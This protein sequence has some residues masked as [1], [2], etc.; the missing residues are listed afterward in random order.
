MG[1]SVRSKSIAELEKSEWPKPGAK[2]SPLF[3]RCYEL[4]NKPISS[5]TV[6]DWR[7]LIGQDVGLGFLM[8][9]AVAEIEKDPLIKGEHYRGD[10]L[11]V[12][13]RASPQF[14]RQNPE[15]RSR[16][17]RVL[18]RL[19]SALETLDF[20]EFDTS[21]EALEEAAAEFRKETK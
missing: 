14:F 5:L 7:V 12:I 16:V 21:S 6:D 15:L 18:M 13:L 17:E 4:R 3:K 19:P 1:M 20:I 9:M 10:L 11:A 8:P 2:V